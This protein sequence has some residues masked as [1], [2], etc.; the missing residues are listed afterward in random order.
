M[1]CQTFIDRCH[2]LAVIPTVLSRVDVK[3]VAKIAYAMQSYLDE[4][5]DQLLAQHP[6]D[7]CLVTSDGWSGNVTSTTTGCMGSYHIVRRGKL[8]CEFG[9]Q[10]ALL[11]SLRPDGSVE[12]AMRIAEP[13]G[14]RN[15]KSAWHCLALAATF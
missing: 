14:M 10:R 12:T 8:R 1:D 3:D 9:L 4:R 2:E 11:K 13:I 6:D 5:W 15:G 7:I